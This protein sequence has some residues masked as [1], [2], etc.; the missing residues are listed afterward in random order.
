MKEQV[1]EWLRSLDTISEVEPVTL[2]IGKESWEGA[3]YTQ[4]G[5]R[6]YYLVGELPKHYG[7]S[8]KSCYRFPETSDDWYVACFLDNYAHI[9]EVKKHHHPFGNNWIM[10][11][12]DVGDLEIDHHR[13]KSGKY[14]RREVTVA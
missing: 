10:M 1:A 3:V 11:R 13:P 4:R 8:P 5:R 9:E 14:R 6:R 2:T 12:W 7:R